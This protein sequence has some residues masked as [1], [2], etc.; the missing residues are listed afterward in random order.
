MV[1][2]THTHLS[3]NKDIPLT[4]LPL[5]HHVH[6]HKKRFAYGTIELGEG[7]TFKI[8]QDRSNNMRQQQHL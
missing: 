4:V 7:D 1:A 6:A 3:S 2:T 5:N 8:L